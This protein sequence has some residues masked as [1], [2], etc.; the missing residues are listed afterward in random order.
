M[1][2]GPNCEHLLRLTCSTTFRAPADTKA[3]APVPAERNISGLVLACE[4]LYNLYVCSGLTNMPV[5]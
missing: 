5:P 2:I 3:P 1:K 4:I